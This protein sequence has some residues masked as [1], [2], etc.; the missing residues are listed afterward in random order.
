MHSCRACVSSLSIHLPLF[1]DMLFTDEQG[2]IEDHEQEGEEDD[3]E[4]GDE[5]HVSMPSSCCS[6]A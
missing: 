1:Q 4:E 2:G 6:L 3:E 5:L